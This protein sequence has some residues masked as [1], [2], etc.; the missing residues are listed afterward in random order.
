MT[1]LELIIYCRLKG[2]VTDHLKL[3]AGHRQT[4]IQSRGYEVSITYTKN[5]YMIANLVCDCLGGN[6]QKNVLFED[7]IQYLLGPKA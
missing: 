3:R 5:G 7:L 4:I 1:L 6:E 2:R